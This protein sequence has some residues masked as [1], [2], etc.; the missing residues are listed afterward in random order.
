MQVYETAHQFAFYT[1]LVT[2]IV[3]DSHADLFPITDPELVY[4]IIAVLRLERNDNIILFNTTHHILAAIVQIDAKKSVTIQIREIVPNKVLTPTIHWLLPLLKREAFEDA[5][6]TLTELGAQSIQPILTQKTVRFFG[7]EKEIVRC[8][9][10]LRAA[11]EQSKQFVVPLLQPIIPL[12][13]WLMKA[14]APNTI[15]IFFDAA[16]MPF[17]QVLEHIEHQK[18]DEIIA[19]AGPEGDLTYEEKQVLIDQGFIFCTLTKTVLRAQQAIAVGLG[20][21]RSML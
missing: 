10:I 16:G 19:C 13:I 5:L 21:L 18:S 1:E 15:K 8:Q 11:A 7:G 9:K 12:D 2:S 6:Y 14:H 17:K 3:R 20:G 4:R